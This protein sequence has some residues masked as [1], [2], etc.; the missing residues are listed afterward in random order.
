MPRPLDPAKRAAIEQAIRNGAGECSRNAIA[1]EFGVAASTVSRIAADAGIEDAFDRS[2]TFRASRARVV[3]AKAVRSQLAQDYLADAVR[4]R[5]R[6]WLPADVVAPSGEVVTLELPSARDVKDFMSSVG[7]AIKISM[8]VE[9]HDAA[10]G[11][12]V[13]EARSM[14]LGVAE[15]L[16][17]LYDRSGLGGE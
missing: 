5:E 14:L 10:S 1:R 4:V 13:D 9:K 6:L 2:K 8:E 11:D 16:R 3:D 15:G 17:S 7:Q 12:A